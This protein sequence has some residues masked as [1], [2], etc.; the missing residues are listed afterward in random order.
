MNKPITIKREEFKECMTG[1]INDSGLP[2]FIIEPILQ[3]LLIE[4]KNAAR[5]QYQHDLKQYEAYLQS[6]GSEC[7]PSEE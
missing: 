2:A 1:I 4:V 7:C 5:M 3:E 6:V